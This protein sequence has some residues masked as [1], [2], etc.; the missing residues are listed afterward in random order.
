MPTIKMLDLHI[1]FAD[2]AHL[3][4][5][6]TLAWPVLAYRVTLP[7]TAEGGD[8]ALN[9]FERLLLTLLEIDGPVSEG[10]LA[11]ETC[12]PKDFVKGVLL[13]LQDNGYIDDRNS[14][15][16][17]SVSRQS[18][19]NFKPAMIFRE[20]VGG[21]VLPY[22]LYDTKPE[23]KLVETGRDIKQMHWSE[24]RFEPV[25][26]QE[27]VEAVKEQKRHERVYGDRSIVP[28]VSSVTVSETGE[29]YF[30]ECPIGMRSTDGEFRI[31][32][33]FGKGYSLLL[34]GV[35]MDELAT[36]ENLEAWI[37][38]WR[39]N[40]VF[41]K[42]PDKSNI[43]LEPYETDRCRHLYPHLLPFLK[44]N[45]YGIRTIEQLYS[46]IEWTLF[47]SNERL[48]SRS[49]LNLLS[50]SNPS[51]TPYLV[52]RAAEAVGVE[53][54]DNGFL[55]I[56]QL[57]ID[58]YRDG[59]PE[60]PTAL[61]IALLQAQSDEMHPLR[62][63]AKEHPDLAIRLYQMKKERD[64]RSHGKGRG[65]QNEQSGKSETFMKELVSALLPG[66]RFSNEGSAR[67][68]KSDA[69]ID[70]RFE[71]RT[72][73]LDLFGYTAFNTKLLS[74]TQERL[75]DAESF[76]M[77]YEEGE[78][79]LSFVGDL[80]AA[81]QSELSNRTETSTIRAK[82]DRELAAEIEKRAKTLKVDPLP[83]SLS[84]VRPNNIRKALQGLDE[85]TLGG[86]AIAFMMS[87]D[88]EEMSRILEQDRPFF[89]D[90]SEVIAARGHLN[91]ARRFTKKEV[92][93]YRK[94]AYRAI[95]TLMEN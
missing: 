60:M 21:K 85:T 18:R 14:I 38:E 49:A 25:S 33:P 55:R 35:F 77:S 87:C 4:R 80:Y 86:V 6:R 10:R 83:K 19:T 51:D 30:L 50:V 48:G 29:R 9:P 40:L 22:V 90:I 75:V 89:S 94:V 93:R 62:L 73:L 84:T 5:P 39:K 15:V 78:D 7:D 34:E 82:N 63:F 28:E 68:S 12:I 41:E 45:Y 43:A 31:G 72:S 88:D 13:R 47:Y 24:R 53:T 76:W 42:G 57:S 23:I 67:E 52:K 8:D 69:L 37:T 27:V 1:S 26:A 70:A 59:V 71:A 81:L 20:N 91:E 11:K 32:N 64:I 61:S 56:N 95:R 44:P 46:S 16:K 17:K 74:I 92:D 79:A 65:A 2:D 36:D 58:S 66:I 3:T 54:P